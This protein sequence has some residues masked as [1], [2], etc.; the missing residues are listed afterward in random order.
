M[1]A[2]APGHVSSPYITRTGPWHCRG[3]QGLGGR[4][5]WHWLLWPQKHGLNRLQPEGSTVRSKGAFEGPLLVWNSLLSGKA[6]SASPLPQVTA[7]PL[8]ARG[9]PF[10][11]SGAWFPLDYQL[12]SHTRPPSCAVRLGRRG[13][14]WVQGGDHLEQHLLLCPVVVARPMPASLPTTTALSS[15]RS[16]ALGSLQPGLWFLLS[17]V[18]PWFEQGLARPEPPGCV[19]K[20]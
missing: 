2:W 12:R 17:R 8:P 10:A 6:L 18:P 13:G 3:R 14:G 9:E 1:G 11:S 15:P 4:G 20:L 19:Y 16:Q 5:L 7:A